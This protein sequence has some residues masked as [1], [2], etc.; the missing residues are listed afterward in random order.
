M[1]LSAI[2][3]GSARSAKIRFEDDDP[4]FRRQRMD[5]QRRPQSSEAPT[6]DRDLGV[7]LTFQRFRCR[8][9]L[10]VLEPERTIRPG[11]GD[12]LPQPDRGHPQLPPTR[13]VKASYF[14]SSE[15]GMRQGV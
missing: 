1:N 13:L 10:D 11:G 8:F 12:R 14:A 4:D 6:H 15:P 9:R 5:P 7:W 3:S 2:A